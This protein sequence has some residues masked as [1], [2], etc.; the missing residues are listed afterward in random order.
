MTDMAITLKLPD[1]L[2]ERINA[3]DID[4]DVDSITSEVIALLERRLARK[5]AWERL[6]ETAKQLRGT[7][8]PE[9][10]EAEL[11]AAT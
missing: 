10:I 4:L 1:D 5:Q 9:K 2:V 11:L 7:L 3:A 8:T 6:H